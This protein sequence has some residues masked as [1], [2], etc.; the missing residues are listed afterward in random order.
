M[1]E[2]ENSNIKTHTVEHNILF[3]RFRIT[4]IQSSCSRKLKKKKELH[5]HL[6]I[7]RYSFWNNYAYTLR[8]ER[9]KIYIYISPS[10]PRMGRKRKTLKELKDKRW[11][12]PTWF[13]Q[14]LETEVGS[15]QNNPEE[16]VTLSPFCL[17]SAVIFYRWFYFGLTQAFSQRHF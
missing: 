4:Y 7:K 1:N 12:L 6:F 17:F 14:L 13:H 10:P 15:S 2:F 3:I 5:A 11:I 16:I 9:K 8:K